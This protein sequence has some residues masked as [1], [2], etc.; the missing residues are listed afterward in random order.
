[1]PRKNL[2]PDDD[3]DV[4]AWIVSFS[5]MVTLLLAF[6]VLLQAFASEKSPDLFFAGRGSFERAIHGL[7]IPD[8][9]LGRRN[10]DQKDWRRIKYPMPEDE[11][12][13]RRRVRD[14]DE[15]RMRELF[16][17]MRQTSFGLEA[18]N[19]QA[20]IRNTYP[21]AVAFNRH[22]IVLDAASKAQIDRV[23]R[24]IARYINERGIKVYILV[25]SP[26][27]Q[28]PDQRT[29]A[30]ARRGQAVEGHLRRSLA[31]DLQ[32]PERIQALTVQPGNEWASQF[33][34]SDQ[35]Q[36]VILVVQE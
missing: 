22:G 30:S 2:Q 6:F 3:D 14:Y 16:N 19:I 28:D 10:S 20:V 1:M 15:D 21:T 32:Q 35:Q 4:P 5:D 18:M 11:R 12:K 8:L 36:V 29:M 33:Q 31:R 34:T 25:Y 23:A 26:D 9:L 17:Q 7:G 13:V 24:Q 27:I